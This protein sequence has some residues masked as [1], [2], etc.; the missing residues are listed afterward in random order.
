MIKNNTGP[1]CALAPL[2]LGGLLP[3]TGADSSEH[4]FEAGSAEIEDCAMPDPDDN[5]THSMASRRALWLSG[6]Q[7]VQTA[8]V[9]S[10]TQLRVVYCPAY[11]DWSQGK[12]RAQ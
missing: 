1:W 7:M 3:G 11:V 2:L 8:T 6:N 9:G 12:L 10:N 5:S 4:G